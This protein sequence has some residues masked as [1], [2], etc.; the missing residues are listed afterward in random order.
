MPKKTYNQAGTSEHAE[1]VALFDW[2][3]QM[4]MYVPELALL[5]AIPNGAKLP[6]RKDKRGKRYSPEAK[7]LIA[8]GLKAGVLDV[9]LPIPRNG[10]HGM[11][12]EM[13]IG[14]NKPSDKQRAW[15][16]A[17]L[18]QGYRVDV[19]YSA[20]DAIRAICDYLGIEARFV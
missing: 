10:Y 2:A 11:W 3:K 9:C 1:Q 17:L 20:D 4:E 18:E 14:N 19:H 5:F 16:V 6:W 8:E 13:K 12:I 7:H 15:I